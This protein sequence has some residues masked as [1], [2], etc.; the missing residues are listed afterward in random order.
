MNQLLVLL[1][2]FSSAGN[3]SLS[4]ICLS[5]ADE[6][7]FPLISH[8]KKPVYKTPIPTYTFLQTSRKTYTTTQ[9]PAEGSG[10][11]LRRQLLGST[12]TADTIFKLFV[13]FF[14]ST[15][16]SDAWQVEGTHTPQNSGR[17]TFTCK[18]PNSLRYSFSRY[19]FL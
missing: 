18:D 4:Q 14:S 1:I 9:S 15:S 2:F 3:E 8:S 10:I 12:D 6:H 13:T 11:P 5:T 19:L 7:P 16:M 17:F